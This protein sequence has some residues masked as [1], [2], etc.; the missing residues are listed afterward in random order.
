M[1][2]TYTGDVLKGMCCAQL[3]QEGGMKYSIYEAKHAE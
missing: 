2:Y 3:D 1:D